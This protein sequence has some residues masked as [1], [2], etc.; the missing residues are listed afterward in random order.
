MTPVPNAAA[1]RTTKR[2]DPRSG[3][4]ARGACGGGSRRHGVRSALLLRTEATAGGQRF[5][6]A[7]PNYAVLLGGFLGAALGNKAVF[8]IEVPQ[9]WA[10]HGGF[11]GFFRGG[12]SMV[13][14]L[15]GGLIGVEI[16]KK[17]AGVWHSTG[18]RFVF[19]ILLGLIIGRIGCFLAGLN[20]DTYGLPTG[21]PWGVDFGDGVPRHPTQLYEIGFAALL[22]LALRRLRAYGAAELGLLFK[23]M[24]S[25]YPLWRLGVDTIKPVPYAY[26]LGAFRHSVGVPR[27]PRR[28]CSADR[29]AMGEVAMSRKTRPYLFYDTTAPV[30]SACLTRVEAKI[31]VKDGRVFLE[32]WCPQHGFERVLVAD[33]ADYYRQCRERW[34]KPSELPL[35]FSTEMARGCPWDCGLCPDHMQH[36]RLTVLEITEHCNLRC[37]VCYAGS[38]P[39][40]RRHRSLAEV[41]SMLDTIVAAEG[42]PDVVQISGGEPTLHPEFFEILEAARKRPIRHL[43]INTKGIRLARDPGFVE[44]LAERRRGLEIYLQFDS[45]DDRVLRELRGAD[46]AR[47]HRDALDRLNAHS[48]PTA[49]LAFPTPAPDGRK[50]TAFRPNTQRTMRSRC[51]TRF[52]PTISNTCALRSPDPRAPCP[53]GKPNGACGTR[54][55]AK[56][57]SKEAPCPNS[58][59]MAA[60]SRTASSAT[61][62][63]AR[64]AKRRCAKATKNCPCCSMRLR[65]PYRLPTMPLAAL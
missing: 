10:E 22:W 32:T 27:R 50:S 46:L 19:P 34:I 63:S 36:S 17:L 18:D 53:I 47:V 65:Y 51:S 1:S 57:G 31:L 37:P 9:L 45:L 48:N 38:G 60:S 23:L 4:G 54:S 59:R 61:S 13:G 3:L 52:I 2:H 35:R 24:L 56:S 44:R 16:A 11:A 33:D 26:P 30:C 15:L 6:L 42:E 21:L 12:Q 62:P 41:E 58:S 20:D 5:P 39:E 7:G 55:G 64:K 28:L 43:M 14:G 49:P 25:S 40:R 29:E 8:W